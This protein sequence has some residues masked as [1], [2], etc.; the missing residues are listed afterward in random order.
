MEEI[1]NSM[2][3]KK[4]PTD[5]APTL[6]LESR[7]GRLEVGVEL[8]TKEIQE[9]G[10]NVHSLSSGLGDFKEKI[11]ANIG[12]ATTPKWPL[13]VSIGSLIIT[14]MALAGGIAS[15][16]F[17]GQTEAIKE[18]QAVA[19]Y[20]TNKQ[21]DDAFVNGQVSAWRPQINEDIKGLNDKFQTQAN[22]LVDSSKLRTQALSDKFDG[23]FK[24]INTRLQNLSDLYEDIRGWRLKHSE[25][26]MKDR[27]TVLTRIEDTRDVVNKL[28]HR[29]YDDRVNRLWM[30][31]MITS[32]ANGNFVEIPR[33]SD[34]DEPVNKK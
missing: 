28:E 3:T 21:L 11:L 6:Q 31:E 5:I 12:Q 10:Q 32:K 34:H 9:I 23:E 15:I 27:A 14:I 16:M 7:V 4:T 18:V 17:S 13:I 26:D 25:E 22:L 30:K 33:P 20:L 2:V 29:Q 1:E 24:V 8:L 19:K